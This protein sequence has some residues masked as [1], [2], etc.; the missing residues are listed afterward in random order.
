MAKTVRVPALERLADGRDFGARLRTYREAKGMSL[1]ELAR[2]ANV[3][4]SLISQIE[5]DKVKPSVNTLYA[6]VT[7]L[8]VSVDELL[9]PDGVEG[10]ASAAVITRRPTDGPVAAPFGLPVHDLRQPME[11]PPI[12]PLQ[13]GDDRKV[14]QLD[15]GVR[16][17]RLT[18][19]SVPGVDFLY[20]VYEPGG[21]SSPADSFQRH[22]GREWGYVLRGTLTVTIAFDEY[23]LGPGDAVTFD[24]S[25]PHRLHNRGAEEAHG[26]WFVLGRTA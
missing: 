22:S 21:S 2:R 20:V 6:V 8:G 1:R 26:V 10:A 15:S 11:H 18:A 17:E 7:E 14:I 5:T 16:W 13:R 24:S 3:S 25:T 19:Q 9:F 23:T 12:P 4:A